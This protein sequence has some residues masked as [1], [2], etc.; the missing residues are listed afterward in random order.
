MSKD[1]TYVRSDVEQALPEWAKVRDTVAGEA[2]VKA[3]T[4][5]YLPKPNPQDTSDAN[6][7]RYEQ[8]LAR[9]S[10]FNATGRTLAGMIGIA[11]RRWPE[12][13]LPGAMDDL[14][15]NIDG[16]GT[17]L[18]NQMQ[19]CLENVL[20]TG[21]DGLL[22]D[23]PRTGGASS[24]ADQREQG[25]QPTITRYKAESI[26]NWRTDERGRTTLVVLVETHQ[27][28]DGYGVNA[29]DQWR[30]LT[31]ISEEA[32]GRYLQRLW[33]K[34]SAGKPQIVEQ[35]VPT[36]AAGQ[37]WREIPFVAVGA[38]DNAIE[39]DRA[40]LYDLAALNI[41]H[42]R[43]SADYEESVYF[44]G[45]PTFVFAG[46]DEQWLTDVWKDTVYVGCRAP[47]ALPQGGPATLLQANANNLAGEAMKRKEEQ[48]IALGARLLT[49]GEAVKTAEQSRADTAAAHSVLSL[50]CDNV[51]QAYTQALNWAARF[52]GAP[53]DVTVSIYTDFTGLVADPQLVTALVQGWQSGA[54]PDADLWAALRQI[55]II[56]PDKDDEDVRDELDAQ[57][58]GLEL[59][60][61]PVPAVAEA[62]PAE[63]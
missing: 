36:D 18:I 58:G 10:F 17:G 59:E 8:Y 6:A 47:V 3:G 1:I 12:V 53:D 56:S 50:A 62:P 27:E 31:L 48:M 55:G 61:E 30:E 49:P 43:N 54:F 28:P 40:P 11:F 44:C 63:E 7:T 22:T 20:I 51:S 5:T 26:A 35:F 13:E 29:V 46:L 23:Y 39:I 2:Q 37:P 24:V 9:A 15:D 60:D 38:V 32:P 34:D 19:G 4:T 41:A 45:Q 14:Q 33:R 16:A 21:R 57:G 25:L 42:Y 52:A